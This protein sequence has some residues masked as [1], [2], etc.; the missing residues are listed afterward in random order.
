LLESGTYASIA[1][2]ET[3]AQSYMCRGSRLTLLA[4]DIV[5]T[6]LVGRQ[7][8]PAMLERLLRSFPVEWEAQ[9]RMLSCKRCA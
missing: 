8:A 2:A 1:E 6:I 7:P 5:E 3:I 9:R 4:P